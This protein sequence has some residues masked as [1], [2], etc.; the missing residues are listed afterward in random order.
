MID[1]QDALQQHITRSV[2]K[3]FEQ[4]PGGPAAR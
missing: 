2:A 1:D 4:F 3:M